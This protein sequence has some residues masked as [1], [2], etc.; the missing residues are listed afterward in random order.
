MGKGVIIG[1]NVHVGKNV[2]IW[3]YV[4][5]GDSVRIGD[6]TRIGSFCDIGK[7]A[8]IGKDCNIQ[9]HVTISNQCKIGNHVFIGPNSTILNDKFPQCNYVAPPKIRD[10]A[11]IGGGVVILPNV[12]IGENS[13]VAAGS[14]VTKNVVPE[15]VVAG[16][17]AKKMMTRK[18]YEVKKK[19]FVEGKK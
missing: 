14:V 13:V 6:K 9:T 11:I 4:V 18:E 17:P 10:G 2:V 5:V 12:E 8:I 16:L 19:T 1:E 7:N 15:A 3:N